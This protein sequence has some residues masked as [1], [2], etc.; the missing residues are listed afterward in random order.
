[1]DKETN[2]LSQWKLRS[3]GACIRDGY[4]LYVGKFRKIFRTTWL[5]AVVYAL[6]S[7]ITTCLATS[8]SSFSSH[9]SL[10]NQYL[11]PIMLV[12]NLLAMLVLLSVSS[13]FLVKRA[14]VNT[15]PFAFPIRYWG[16]AI[17]VL[18]MVAF[19]TMSLILIT[20]LPAIVLLA[21]GMVSQAGAFQGDPT[22][23]PDY[24]VWTNLVVFT[25]AGFIQ[26]FILLSTLFP[27]YYLYGS[28]KMQEKE[29]TQISF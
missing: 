27:F 25:L 6:F 29:R 22:G 21:A 9:T 20:E 16:G 14:G 1:M 8:L 26:A 4:R 18:M 13:H 11:T 19:V 17:L 2:E 12:V 24:M 5:A 10:I 15:K 3:V 23:M 28:A 7:G